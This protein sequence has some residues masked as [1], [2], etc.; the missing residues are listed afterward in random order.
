[1]PSVGL[2]DVHPLE[3]RLKALELIV[4]AKDV[5]C[6]RHFARQQRLDTTT[7]GRFHNDASSSHY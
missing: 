5:M 3:A 4:N 2:V 6:I 7:N 1:M